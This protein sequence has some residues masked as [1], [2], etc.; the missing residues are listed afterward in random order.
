M[1]VIISDKHC[2]DLDDCLK[3]LLACFRNWMSALC[4]TSS[5]TAI[6]FRVGS[7]RTAKGR[8]GRMGRR[9]GCLP[10]LAASRQGFGLREVSFGQTEKISCSF[11]GEFLHLHLR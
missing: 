2:T 9:R 4:P 7:E 3:L 10:N 1:I 8:E 5:G 6:S 11:G